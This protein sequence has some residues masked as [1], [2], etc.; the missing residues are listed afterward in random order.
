MKKK[1]N[2]GFVL[3]EVLVASTLIITTFLTLYV[4]LRR[5]VNSFN[6]SF[7]YNTIDE[8]YGAD[9]I[10]E[11]ISINGY[12][13]LATIIDSQEAKYKYVNITSCSDSYFI[14]T[15]YCQLL[16]EKLKIENIYFTSSNINKLIEDSNVRQIFSNEMV[17]YM[18]TIVPIN[19]SVKYRII[20]EYKNNR[21]ATLEFKA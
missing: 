18:K 17:K 9:T 4:Q 3:T 14:N 6:D 20:V 13:K 7:Y 1:N 16:F 11:Y 10:R 5:V 12:N 2:K 19:N 15:N 8:L 21:Y